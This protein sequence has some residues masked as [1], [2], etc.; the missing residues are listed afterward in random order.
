MHTLDL[1]S[2][3]RGFRSVHVL[4]GALAVPVIRRDDVRRRLLLISIDRDGGARLRGCAPAAAPA[5][6]G[7]GLHIDS[8]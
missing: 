4:A 7:S 2:T 6:G 5:A 1:L 8:A 3:S